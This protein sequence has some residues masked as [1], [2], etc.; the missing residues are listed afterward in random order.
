MIHLVKICAANFLTTLS[1]RLEELRSNSS[2]FLIRKHTQQAGHIAKSLCDLVILYKRVREGVD[3]VK[4]CLTECSKILSLKYWR[5]LRSTE[6][7][8]IL[9]ISVIA[10]YYIS[11]NRPCNYFENS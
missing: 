6:Y 3:L 11:Y 1:T 10:Y 7:L 5:K 8:H 9:A 2:L 4:F